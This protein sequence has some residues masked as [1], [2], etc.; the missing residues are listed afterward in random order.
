M[1]KIFS[2]RNNGSWISHEC[3]I[4][5]DSDFYKCCFRDFSELNPKWHKGFHPRQQSMP[6]SPVFIQ[7]A[8]DP[9]QYLQTANHDFCFI[10]VFKIFSGYGEIRHECILNFHNIAFL[11]LFKHSVFLFN[12]PINFGVQ[13]PH[14]SQ[15]RLSPFSLIFQYSSTASNLW[16][17]KPS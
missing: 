10:S 8:L 16:L 17:L 13:L 14:K 7:T 3:S 11:V 9:T 12:L 15:H 6:Q 2:T 4:M 5:M 1:C